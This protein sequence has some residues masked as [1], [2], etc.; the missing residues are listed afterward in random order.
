MKKLPASQ[1]WLLLLL[2]NA[3]PFV[4]NVLFYTS[5]SIDELVWFVPV[6]L[7]LTV[8]NLKNTNKFWHYLVLNLF[9]ILCIVA[10]GAAAVYL[11]YHN[12]S[13]DPETPLVGA[14]VTMIEVYA[15]V[16][17]AAVV[18]AVRGIIW[19]CRKLRSSGKNKQE[20]EQ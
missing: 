3:A 4:L 8:C 17:T 7:A 10:L 12:I 11:Y 14:V 1:R 6:L 5:G 15:V 20:P 16:I 13:S 19:L 2:I 18:C 9:D